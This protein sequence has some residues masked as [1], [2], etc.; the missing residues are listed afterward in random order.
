MEQIFIGHIFTWILDSWGVSR[1]NHRIEGQIEML[2]T[3]W[4]IC[5]KNSQFFSEICF[6]IWQQ[7]TPKFTVFKKITSTVQIRTLSI[8]KG[9]VGEEEQVLWSKQSPQFIFKANGANW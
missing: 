4:Q 9:Q 6:E 1:M 5:I 7:K 3:Y 8:G 2:P